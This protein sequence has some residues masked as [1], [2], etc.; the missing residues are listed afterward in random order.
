M[1]RAIDYVKDLLKAMSWKYV[2]NQFHVVNVRYKLLLCQL[3]NVMIVNI[4]R[5]V[6][7]SIIVGTY[8]I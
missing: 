4:D 7:A 6:K 1:L 2:R 3:N 5:C 8:A